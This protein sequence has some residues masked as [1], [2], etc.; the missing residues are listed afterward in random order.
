MVES[1]SKPTNR[2]ILDFLKKELRATN[3][4]DVFRITHNLVVSNGISSACASVDFSQCMH[5][6]TLPGYVLKAYR[7]RV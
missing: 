6:T 5:G 1:I 3:D 4:C 2:E 7:D